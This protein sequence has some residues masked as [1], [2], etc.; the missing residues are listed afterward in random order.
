MKQ[1]FPSNL[2]LEFKIKKNKQHFESINTS[3]NNNKSDKTARKDFEPD[4]R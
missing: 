4:N 2:V 3:R 1:S